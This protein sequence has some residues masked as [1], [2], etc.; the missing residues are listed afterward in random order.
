MYS[1]ATTTE[2]Y[3]ADLPAWQAEYLEEFR[4][5]IH[6]SANEVDEVIKWGTPVFM[7]KSKMVFAMSAFKHHVKYNFFYN[8]AQLSDPDKLFNNGFTAKKSRAIDRAEGQEVDSDK[9]RTLVAA[10]FALV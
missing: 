8:G 7:Y 3:L 1:D 9:L 4:Q 6:A 5:A 10:S 2:E